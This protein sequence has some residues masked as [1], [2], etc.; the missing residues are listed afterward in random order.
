MKQFLFLLLLIAGRIAADP[1]VDMDEKTP[2]DDT[3]GGG[4]DGMEEDEGD[5]GD[6]YV[7]EIRDQV[8][9][10]RNDTDDDREKRQTY[11]NGKCAICTDAVSI[12]CLLACRS[13]PRK[14]HCSSASL[15][16]V[17]LAGV[18]WLLL[19]Q[20]SLPQALHGRE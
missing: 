8:E 1:D 14:C 17:V 18:S 20:K 16:Q 12:K 10:P 19:L 9:G 6:D 15:L 2:D 3:S 7:D 11:H 13:V 4:D 5:P